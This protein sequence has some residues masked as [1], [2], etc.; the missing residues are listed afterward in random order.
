M[1]DI[2]GMYRNYTKIA[3]AEELG[4]SDFIGDYLFHG[5]ELFGHNEHDKP[6]NAAG[7]VQFRH[8]ANPLT[9]V[10]C[11]V[12]LCTLTISEIRKIHSFQ[13]KPMMPR[14]YHQELLRPPLSQAYLS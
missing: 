2:P 4:M 7:N 3:A 5:K 9:V 10:L 8:Q 6:Q 11:P 1:R 14:G 12:C 13:H